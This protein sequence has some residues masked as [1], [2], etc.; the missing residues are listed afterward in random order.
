MTNVEQGHDSSIES[1]GVK[2]I[3][4]APKE[5]A[6]DVNALKTK[7]KE[8]SRAEQLQKEY[9]PDYQ[10]NL[11]A[12]AKESREEAIHMAHLLGKS[13][14]AKGFGTSFDITGGLEDIKEAAAKA[15]RMGL[16]EMSK[17]LSEI[18]NPQKRERAEQEM[19]KNGYE[20]IAR[21]PAEDRNADI[22]YWYKPPGLEAG[23]TKR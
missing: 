15:D 14:E 9:G 18:S 8:A 2:P 10:D 5:F 17:Y 4:T 20:Q 19:A 13:A 22:E 7:F 21:V 23:S 11:K 3:E 12:A 1:G 16:T 6:E